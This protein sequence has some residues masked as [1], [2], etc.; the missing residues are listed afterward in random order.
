MII[1][2]DFQRCCSVFSDFGAHIVLILQLLNWNGFG[3]K[4]A[5]YVCVMPCVNI[6]IPNHKYLTEKPK[7]CE[8]YFYSDS[9]E[10][11]YR[12]QNEFIKLSVHAHYLILKFS[13]FVYL[14]FL[15]SFLSLPFE[16]KPV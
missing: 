15:F 12:N 2:L 6:S 5:E 1:S 4:C 16:R 11:T 13:R 8:R 9:V 10:H 3:K 14:F 7:M